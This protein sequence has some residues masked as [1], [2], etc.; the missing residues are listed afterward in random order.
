MSDV[1]YQ[2]VVQK[3]VKK[4]RLDFHFHDRVPQDPSKI[5]AS[6]ARHAWN[7]HHEKKYL[8]PTPI[9][10]SSTESEIGHAT[11]LKHLLSTS[12]R[13]IKIKNQP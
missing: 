11:Y 8:S 4:T 1:Q 9:F 5:R 13:V 3:G 10:I 7:L 12:C 6:I 2:V